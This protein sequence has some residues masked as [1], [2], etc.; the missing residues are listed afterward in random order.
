HVDTD[1]L[2]HKLDE[3][4]LR[5]MHPLQRGL[6]AIAIIAAVGPLLGLLGTVTGIIE[7]FQSI[8]LFGT[9]DPRLMSAG[10]SEALVTTVL[11]L[12][13]AIPLLFIHSFLSSKSNAVI[14]I[15]DQ[16]SAAYIAAIAESEHQAGSKTAHA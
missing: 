1:T 16:Q 8:T 2:G 12:V 4:I 15:L 5:E 10:I 3:T 9:G 7:T 14:Q 11:G 13:I 6:G